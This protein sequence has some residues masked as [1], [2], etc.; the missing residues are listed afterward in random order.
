MDKPI[1]AEI[2]NQLYDAC[3]DRV[4]GI[5]R[6][7]VLGANPKSDFF[8]AKRACVL[9]SDNARQLDDQT[10]ALK[11]R[12]VGIYCAVDKVHERIVDEAR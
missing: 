7:E 9:G 11:H 10:S 3:D 12:A 8:V 1:G 2:F 6:H 5:G 4:T